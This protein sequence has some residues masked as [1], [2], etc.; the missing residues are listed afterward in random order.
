MRRLARY[1]PKSG[2]VFSTVVIVLAV[3]PF[4]WS[5]LVWIGL[6]PWFVSIRRC[7]SFSE[8][9]V[10][11]MWLNVL[12]GLGGA[13]WVVEATQRYLSAS[14]W[15]GLLALFVH[16]LL[17]QLQ[18]VVFGALY[19][20]TVR[21]APPARL[22]A[23]FG[24]AF[25]YTGLDWLVPK[26]LGDTLG[27]ILYS[28]PWLRQLA[29]FGGA[30]V[31]TFVVLLV[32]L[33]AY[34]GL[35]NVWTASRFGAGHL[36]P[37]IHSLLRLLLPLS[38]LLALGAVEDA[39]INDALTRPTR[40]LHVAIVQGSVADELRQRWARGDGSAARESL[41]VYVRRTKEA[42]ES[43]DP[44]DLI[45]WP[46][47]T[48]PGV[49]RKPE[50]DWQLQLNVAFDR[51]IAAA[52]VPIAFGAYDR[53]D[54]TD[55]RVLRNAL[56]LVSPQPGQTREKLSPMQVY[57]KSILFPV[58]EYFPFL[59]EATV[60]NWFPHSAHLAPGSGPKLLELV[61]PF[62]DPLRLGPSICYEDVFASHATSLARL[63]AELLINISNDS[64]F[65]DHGAAQWHLM[66]A[67]LR[68]VETRLPQVR[69]TNSGYSA[70]ILPNG[71]VHEVS[72]FGTETFRTFELPVTAPAA[73]LRV[74]FGD[75]FGPLALALGA[76][77]LI[78]RRRQGADERE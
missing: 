57:H 66:M 20:R 48:Y 74:R 4:E 40:T 35:S 12:L 17:H 44:L 16:S 76:V 59:D 39:R 15:V 63:G 18:L 50:S 60:R 33:G 43:S 78:A 6:V 68:S 69:A 41:D 51:F 53:E 52:G 70:F 62:S 30:P 47:T 56:Y 71:E 64:W 25:L 19:W 54:R 36:R 10:Q 26:L 49:F 28:Y 45:L 29:A 75:W 55:R 9:V 67:T 13:F 5:W 11:G 27:M 31:L 42:L 21:G 37:L 14:P 65:G 61:V 58:G 34:A 32:N 72:E 8:A 73:T 7:R 3:P 22:N 1:A 2:T 77:W 46:E 23:L 24:L 38:A